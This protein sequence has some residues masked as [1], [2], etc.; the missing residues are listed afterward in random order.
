VTS[1]G[2]CSING[3]P[4][5]VLDTRGDFAILRVPTQSK[6]WLRIDCNGFVAGHSYT[7]IGFA[8]A[9]DT[10]TTVDIVSTGDRIGGFARLRG[11]FNVIPGQSGGPIVDPETGKVVGT[12]NVYNAERGDS[13]S[14]ELR[15]TSVCRGAA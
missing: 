9:L 4:I 14:T 7:A 10:Q 2:G 8:R 15:G 1:A 6:S 11:V 3:E 13:G 12:V 5:T